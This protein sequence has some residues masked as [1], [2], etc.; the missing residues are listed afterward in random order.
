MAL[1]SDDTYVRCNKVGLDFEGLDF[2]GNKLYTALLLYPTML[3][4]YIYGG[5]L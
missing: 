4:K 2:I 1:H 3:N 5:L